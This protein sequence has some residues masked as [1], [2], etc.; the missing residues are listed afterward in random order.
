MLTESKQKGRM[1]FCCIVVVFA[2]VWQHLRKGTAWNH[3]DTCPGRL[4]IESPCV[5]LLA[6]A[7]FEFDL[8]TSNL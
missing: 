3:L 5:T 2:I 4:K 6:I 8:P 1:S 7:S